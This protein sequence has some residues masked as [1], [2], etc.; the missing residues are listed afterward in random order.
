MSPSASALLK[1]KGLK[2]L[3]TGRSDALTTPSIKQSI[4]DAIAS[5]ASLANLQNKAHCNAGLF[6]TLFSVPITFHVFIAKV[7]GHRTMVK[8]LT[9]GTIMRR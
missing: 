7:S 1:L 8:Q 2:R 3:L 5:A 9:P 4:M 6:D